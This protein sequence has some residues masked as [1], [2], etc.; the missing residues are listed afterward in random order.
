MVVVV[1]TLAGGGCKDD[2]PSAPTSLSPIESVRLVVG[3]QIVVVYGA[4]HLPEQTGSA[5]I[6]LNDTVPLTA[7]F[8]VAHGI[9][10]DEYN[11]PAYQLYVQVETADAVRFSASTEDSHA[12]TLVATAVGPMRL[13]VALT[14]VS[15]GQVVWGPYLA[16]GAAVGS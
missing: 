2:A 9:A 8:R 14:R 3:Q 6:P 12:G 1:I 7:E 10:S 5:T 13:W 16:V 15:D 4:D 11:G